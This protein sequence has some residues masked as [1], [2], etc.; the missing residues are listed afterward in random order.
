MHLNLNAEFDAFII[1]PVKFYLV[2]DTVALSYSSYEDNTV[3][4][5]TRLLRIALLG[6]SAGAPVWLNEKFN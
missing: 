3:E 1:P 5:K 6:F 4:I 2:A